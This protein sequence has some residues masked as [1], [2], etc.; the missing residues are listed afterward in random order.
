VVRQSKYM[1]NRIEQDHRRVKRRIRLMLGFKSD[2]S[3]S[4]ILYGIELIH[5]IRKGQMVT[6]NDAQNLSLAD[7]FD[8]LAA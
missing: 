6:A 7:Q 5:M 3:A 1:N 2:R 4:I 8:S